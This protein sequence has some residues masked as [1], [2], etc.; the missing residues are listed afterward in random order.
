MK[1]WL[2]RAPPPSPAASATRPACSLSAPKRGDL[3]RRGQALHRFRRRHRRAQHRPP[4]PKVMAAVQ[5]RSSGSPIP[6]SRCRLRFL[7]RSR[8]A[9]QRAGA[10]HRLR[11]NGAVLYRRRGDRERDQDR[12]CA[13][14]RAGVIAFTG[15]F[16]GRT[17]MPWDDRQ[18]R[19][20]QEG[21]RP[22]PGRD[23]PRAVPDRASRRDRSRRCLAALELPV[24]GRHR[25]DV[26]RGDHHRAGAGRGRL[27]CRAAG[28]DEGLR[29]L[30]DEHGI[31][32]VADEVQSGF[33]RTGKMFAIEHSGVEPDLIVAKSLAGGFP[34][35]GVIGRAAS[36]T[37]PSPAASAAPTPA[38]RSPARRRLPCSTCSRGEAR[39]SAPSTRGGSSRPAASRSRDRHARKVIG[40]I[41]GL[42]AMVAIELVEDGDAN[43][44]PRAD[45]SARA[46]GRGAGP[47]PA[48]VRREQQRDPLPRRR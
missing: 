24:P 19:A 20:V 5:R 39:S 23:L 10:D 41:R 14:G 48:V 29:A 37:R 27:P 2:A 42:G 7:R 22:V 4:H 46:G 32:L 15:G 12:P 44:D 28:L 21:L 16:H 33:G 26:G 38:T 35:S 18:G 47:D 1:S 6:A 3:G 45:Q 11:E 34:L 31:V 25:P 17:F 9:A 36:W 43:A 8:R 30:C 13:T 40:D